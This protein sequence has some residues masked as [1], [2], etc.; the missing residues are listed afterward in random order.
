MFGLD[1]K[2]G[3]S[4]LISAVAF[5]A[6]IAAFLRKPGEDAK[7]EVA[8]VKERLVKLEERTQHMPDSEELAK[9]EGMV[10]QVDE[11]TA[12]LAAAIDTIR[13][14]QQRIESYLLT[15]RN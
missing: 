3:V 5:F 1:V 2:D 6:S 12:G 11:R 14:S 15:A 10:K 4:L 9:L 13:V 7:M 8:E